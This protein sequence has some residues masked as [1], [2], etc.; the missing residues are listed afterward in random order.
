MWHGTRNASGTVRASHPALT[1]AEVGANYPL[2]FPPCRQSDNT[3]NTQ[4]IYYQDSQP[5]N[6]KTC[7]S[8]FANYQPVTELTK[9]D[10]YRG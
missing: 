2:S 5:E 9:Q 3:I 1:Y 7:E 8:D 10:F 4:Y 6:I